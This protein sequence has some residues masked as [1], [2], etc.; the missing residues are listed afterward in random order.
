LGF[1]GRALVSFPI[2]LLSTVVT[3]ATSKRILVVEDDDDLR[4]LFR[5]ALT[6][7]GFLVDEARSGVDA[8]RQ[9]EHQPDLV[10][11]DLFLPGIDGFGVLEEISGQ[12]G[13]PTPIV[14]VTS[15]GRDLSGLEVSCVLRK[16]VTPAELV[17]TV[18]RCLA[19][20]AGAEGA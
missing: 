13:Q 11:L 4:R 8:L 18:R 5:I 2:R 20:G 7:E 16:P 10:V 3:A 9:F 15:S 1:H 14:I 6:L 19:S 17:A 12:G